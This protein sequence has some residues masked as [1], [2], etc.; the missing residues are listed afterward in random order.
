VP[1]GDDGV[2][3]DIDEPGALAA[4]MKTLETQESG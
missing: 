3:L 1:M 4:F 2:L